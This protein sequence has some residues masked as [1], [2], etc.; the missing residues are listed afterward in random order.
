M[1]K[2]LLASWAASRARRKRYREAHILEKNYQLAMYNLSRQ[3]WSIDFLI[4]LLRKSQIRGLAIRITE[5]SG[6]VLELTAQ[7]PV[8]QE[9]DYTAQGQSLSQDE[10]D[11]LLGIK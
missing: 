1:I 5:P 2:Q 10:W 11:A 4:Y 7:T 6:K 9:N 3:E 8:K